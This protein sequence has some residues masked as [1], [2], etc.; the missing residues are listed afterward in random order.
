MKNARRGTDTRL[1]SPRTYFFQRKEVISNGVNHSRECRPP[2]ICRQT[3]LTRLRSLPSVPHA[4]GVD[5]HNRVMV[6]AV[7]PDRHGE[8]LL[9]G[10]PI[11]EVAVVGVLPIIF[12]LIQLEVA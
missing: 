12:D 5:T 6:E 1:L 2:G 7:A 4:N 3:V 10:S 9:C 8:L 11:D